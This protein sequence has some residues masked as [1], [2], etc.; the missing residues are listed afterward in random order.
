MYV[1]PARASL[2]SEEPELA[3]EIAEQIRLAQ[4][5]QHA[6]GFAAGDDDLDPSLAGLTPM[7]RAK[8]LLKVSCC[9]TTSR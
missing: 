8:V 2:A 6:E 1:Y 5:A 3:K 9:L 4:Q 7:Q